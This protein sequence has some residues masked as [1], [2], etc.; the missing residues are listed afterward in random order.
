MQSSDYLRSL[1]MPASVALVGASSKPGSIG[2]IVLENMLGGAFRGTL[3]AVNP[4]HRRV[5]AQR[6]YASLA[7]IGRSVELALIVVPAAAVPEVFEDVAR[8]GIRVAVILS[9]PPPDPDDARRWQEKLLAI[10]AARGIRLLGPH[11][12]GVIRTDLGLNATLGNAVAH[13]GRLALV[14]Q[15]G[16][17]CS[18]MLDFA[19]SGGIGFST[20]VALGGVMDIG[21]TNCWTRCSS[22]RLK[23]YCFTQKRS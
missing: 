10:A 13:P 7:A 1:L 2:R 22:I 18:A 14:A 17:V 9:P 19:A 6:S 20:V 3:Y 11:S 21:F 12:F 15:S 23:A 16:A 8:A 5:L 4:K